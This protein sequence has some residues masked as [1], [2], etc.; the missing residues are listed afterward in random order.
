MTPTRIPH[1]L[2]LF[3]LGLHVGGCDEFLFGDGSGT[4]PEGADA[5]RPPG[6]G[7]DAGSEPGPTPEV[8]D[9][10]DAGPGPSPEPEPPGDGWP[11]EWAAL[12]AS[13]ID[14]VNQRRAR[15]A[16]CGSESFGPAGPLAMSPTL[17]TA[18]RL[19]SRDMAQQGYFAHES[20]DGR[21]F[22]DRMREA[23]YQGS[24]P[25]GENIASGYPD[26]ASVV[27]GWM[28]SPG[29][30]ENIMN[31]RFGVLGVGYHFEGSSRM[32]SYWTQK[33]GGTDTP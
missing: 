9:A 32:G 16:R 14:L 33:F 3:A 17:R 28:D 13:V 5:S 27:Q 19:H 23:G 30:C 25:W 10:P 4:D 26:A 29:H 15:G 2:L 7:S 22:T 21:R 12:E 6:R 18:A 8:P 31:G 20:L 11:S 1:V 24:G